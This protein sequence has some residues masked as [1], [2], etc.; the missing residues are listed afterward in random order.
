MTAAL[1]T[2][3][4]AVTACATEASPSVAPSQPASASVASEPTPSPTAEPTAEPPTE[5]TWTAEPFP[6]EVHGL[7]QD[8]GRLVAV[9]RDQDGLASWTSTDGAAW[10]RHDVPDPTFIADLVDDFGPQIYQRTRMGPLTRLGATLFSFGTFFSPLDFYRPVGWRSLDGVSWEFIESKNAFYEYG[11]VTDAE[12]FGDTLLAARAVGLTGP[13]YSLWTWTA[14]TSWRESSVRS[15]T[16]G[17]A[18]LVTAL[19][20]AVGDGAVL[21]VGDVA[22]PMNGPQHE[23]PM[24]PVAWRS[25][26]GER[27]D[28]VTV[29]D[30]VDLPHRVAPAPDGGFSV[31]GTGVVGT[32]SAWHTAP[33]G[34]QWTGTDLH[35]CPTPEA[36]DVHAMTRTGNWLVATVSVEQ[37]GRIWLSRDGMNWVRQQ[38]PAGPRPEGPIAELDGTVFVFAIGGSP[39]QPETILLR[40]EPPG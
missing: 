34:S 28:E 8:Q 19:D 26:D 4:L 38:A 20:A 5:L 10:T 13:V 15:V 2:I 3:G 11:T 33:D 27:W 37:R 12:T 40:G 17:I 16:E 21:V 32:I 7:I 39:E 6:G 14:D 1:L 9:G 18:T 23:W 30:D 31:I 25:D 36:C 35:A 22:V 29:P 24:E